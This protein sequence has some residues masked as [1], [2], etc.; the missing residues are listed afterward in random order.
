MVNIRG[1]NE[2]K[3]GGE[4]GAKCAKVTK[5]AKGVKG[6]KGQKDID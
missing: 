3:W 1:D 4:H 2:E 5:D 6:V